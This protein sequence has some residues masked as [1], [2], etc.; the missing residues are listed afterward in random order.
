MLTHSSHHT[1][2][3]GERIVHGPQHVSDN[4]H[5]NSNKYAHTKK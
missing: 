3:R 2:L 1:T 5:D 4:T